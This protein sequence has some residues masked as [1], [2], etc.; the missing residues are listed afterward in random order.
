MCYS[1][2]ENKRK[3]YVKWVENE[4]VSEN[5]AESVY[6]V[7]PHPTYSMYQRG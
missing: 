3:V 5:V 4:T 1:A 2:T 6:D 7:K